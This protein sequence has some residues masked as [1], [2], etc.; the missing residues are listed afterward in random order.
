MYWVFGVVLELV[1]KAGMEKFY[2]EHYAAVMYPQLFMGVT[3]I[4]VD[5]FLSKQREVD[6]FIKCIEIQDEL[7]KVTGHRL[8]TKVSLSDDLIKKYM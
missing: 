7:E 3:G 8:H 2:M 1:R 5:R 6:C 4:H